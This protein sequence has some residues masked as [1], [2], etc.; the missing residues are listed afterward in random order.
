MLFRFL[1]N[2]LQ[3]YG[4]IFF[5]GIWLLGLA[6]ESLSSSPLQ[7]QW[8]ISTSWVVSSG[9]AHGILQAGGEL[10]DARGIQT[11]FLP[12][13]SEAKKVDW[14]DWSESKEPNRG[15]LLDPA[16]LLKKI[17]SQGIDLKKP[18]LVL[19]DPLNGWGE[20]G[21]LVWTLRS[22]GHKKSYLVDGG[23]RAF[24]ELK[25]DKSAYKS[26]S[27]ISF[28]NATSF[29]KQNQNQYS[30][31]KEAINAKEQIVLDVREEREYQGGT[32]YGEERGGH[33]PGAKWVYFKSFVQPN[34]FFKSKKEILEML[35]LSENSKLKIVSYCTGGVRSAFST[36]ILVSY[37]L[38]SQ[39]YAGSMWEWSA[40]DTKK[41]PLVEK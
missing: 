11:R 18:I 16:R 14:E 32:P 31:E 40:S 22:I 3:F 34:G 37:G 30:I 4:L 2:A 24:L 23:A 38:E 36:A 7:K 12:V 19:G 26:V 13:V 35:S 21:R 5:L 17:E 25:K 41:Y 15:K 27:P 28:T 39:N 29:E 10:L 6:V 9:Q 33:I 8:D 1:L 20:E